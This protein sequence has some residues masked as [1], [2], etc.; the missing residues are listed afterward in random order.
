MLLWSYDPDFL[1]TSISRLLYFSWHFYWILFHCGFNFQNCHLLSV[2]YLVIFGISCMERPLD[3]EK[4]K[5][6][7]HIVKNLFILLL[8]TKTLKKNTTINSL[9]LL[10][11]QCN[12]SLCFNALDHKA[13]SLAFVHFFLHVFLFLWYSFFFFF[14]PFWFLHRSWFLIFS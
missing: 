1:C 6:R 12:T 8:K 14:L 3:M 7:I 13:S 4:K 5:R 2:F 11:F 10:L 9:F